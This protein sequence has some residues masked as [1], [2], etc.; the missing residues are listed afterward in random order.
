MVFFRLLRV[1][2]KIFELQDTMKHHVY[3]VSSTKH[4]LKCFVQ[5]ENASKINPHDNVNTRAPSD[6]NKFTTYPE[7]NLNDKRRDSCV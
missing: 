7:R 1:H 2:K 4:S 5:M 6:F 3:G